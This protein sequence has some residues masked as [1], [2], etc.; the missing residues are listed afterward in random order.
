MWV[1]ILIPFVGAAFAVLLFQFH[2][3]LEFPCQALNSVYKANM[4]ESSESE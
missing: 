4:A 3:T 2:K 1:Y